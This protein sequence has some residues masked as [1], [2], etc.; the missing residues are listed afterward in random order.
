M[1]LIHATSDGWVSVMRVYDL[2]LEDGEDFDFTV[3]APADMAREVDGSTVQRDD[4]LFHPYTGWG[5]VVDD[6]TYD[7]QAEPA[8]VTYGGRTWRGIMH[9]SIVRPDSGQ[10]YF[11]VSGAVEDVMRSIVSRQ[12]LGGVFTVT[13]DSGKSVSNFQF[14]RYTDMHSG[15]QKMLAS[16]GL[17]LSVSKGRGLCEVSAVPVID[18]SRGVDGN[19]LLPK[20]TDDRPVNHLVCLGSGELSQRIVVDLYMDASGNVSQSRT[21]SGIQEISEVYDYTSADRDQ[22][23]ENGTERLQDYYTDSR[24]VD[25]SADEMYGADLGDAVTGMS[26]NYPIEVTA[27]VSSVGVKSSNGSDP[28]L[29]YKVGSTK[30]KW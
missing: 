15:I 5:G 2:D 8:T 26:V 4:F 10:D 30:V 13:G 14:D 7:E 6:I 25:V 20:I 17:R 19:L 11:R 16:V 23:I 29:S 12:E 1:D 18:V 24:A 22:L 3:K 9:A 27:T 21:F 28:E